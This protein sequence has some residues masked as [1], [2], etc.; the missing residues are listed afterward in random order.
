MMS[1]SGV[2]HS[3]SLDMDLYKSKLMPLYNAEISAGSLMVAESRKLAAFML[4]NPTEADWQKALGEDNILQKRSPATARRQA[5]LI[6]NRLQL[7]DRQGLEL[8]ATREKE[9][10]VQMLFLSCLRHSL[11]LRD[12]IADVVVA[13]IQRLDMTLTVR[14]WDGF[15]VDCAHRD[16]AVAVWSETTRKKLLQVIL[17]VL[18]EAGYLASTRSLTIRR[19]QLHPEVRRYLDEKDDKKM[20]ALMGL[21]L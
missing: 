13:H 9:V 20:I 2:A 11:L 8:I 21:A 10:V 7:L 12:F 6:R 14:D 16:P 17:R 4:G 1:K 15:L 3:K 5:R 19:V 18:A